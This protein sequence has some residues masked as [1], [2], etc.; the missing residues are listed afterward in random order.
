MNQ[1]AKLLK[2]YVGEFDKIG[3]TPLYEAIVFAAKGEKLAGATV[4]RGIMSFGPNSY[5]HSAKLFD[6]SPDLPIVIDIVD[7][8]DKIELFLSKYSE[9][10]AK[11][12][13]GGLVYTLDV[14]I[15]SYK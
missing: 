13:K 7:N 8:E 14:D 5:V 12:S 10:F 9:I 3:H 1:K 15:R 2:I 11:A 6:I 4:T